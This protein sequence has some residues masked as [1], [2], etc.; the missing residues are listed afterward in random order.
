MIHRTL[1][2]L[3]LL[4]LMVSACSTAAPT[5]PTSTH[6]TSPTIPAT[7]GASFTPGVV[8]GVPVLIPTHTLSGAMP[9]GLITGKLSYDDPCVT[10]SE[11]AVV[12]VPVWPLGFSARRI[13]EEVI[14]A[15]PRGELYAAGH[16]ISL[17]GGV[18]EG[19]S[20]SFVRENAVNLIPAC[21]RGP[22]WLVADVSG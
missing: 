4:L 6:V 18:F 8:D 5:I 14:I 2:I 19:D 3:G 20:A 15:S 7:V 11:R 12:Y 21:D 16:D 13:G 17:T 1:S 10:I 22:F 9:A